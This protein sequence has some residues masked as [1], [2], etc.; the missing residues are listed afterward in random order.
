MSEPA[1]PEHE[2]RPKALR[3]AG[4]SIVGIPTL[5]LTMTLLMPTPEITAE[6]SQESAETN[7]DS[8][9]F[10]VVNARVFDGERT[11]PKATV[12]VENGHIQAMGPDLELPDDLERVDGSGHTLMPG[13]LDAHV[14]TWGSSRADA[15]RFGVT[16][17]LDQFT[18][19]TELQKARKHRDGTG[20]AGLADLFSA[21]YLA[22][23]DGGHGTQF[24]MPV[25]Q[26][27]SPEAADAW[28]KARKEEGSDWIKIVVEPGWGQSLPTLDP[29]TIAALIDA[30]HRQGLKAV[31]HASL[32]DDALRVAELGADGLVHVWR[33]REIDDAELETL[34]RS[35]IFVVPTLVVVE[36]MVDPEP[37]MAL[38]EGPLGS[39]LSA[40]QRASLERRFPPSTKLDW[41]VPTQSVRRLA[42]AGVP[43]LAGSDAPNPS[44]AFGF[45]LHREL[46]LLTE[47]GLSPEQ[48]LRA[49]TS[50]AADHFGVPKRGRIAEGQLADLVLVA[51]DPTADITATQ[52]I[53]KV[54]KSG[55]P[56]K[57]AAEQQAAP[58]IA[59]AP[60]P[61][62]TLLADF[63]NGLS[64]RSGQAW[65]KTTDDRM[66]GKSVVDLQVVDG[67]LRITGELLQGA[68]FPW[69]GAMTFLGPNP[70]VAV[71]FS[72]RKE[73]SFRARGDG[74]SYSVM[75]FS[76]DMQG[77]PPSLTFE[78]SDDWTRI[79][80][81]LKGFRGAEPA[82]LRAVSFAATGQLGGFRFEID[83]VE[84]R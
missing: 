44:T 23:V 56:V 54:W 25:P 40:P 6:A 50:L 11:H 37:S 36:G 41:A 67:A 60:A 64:S 69:A 46:Q 3:W 21:G 80:L 63:D 20:D 83:D 53:R 31:V 43:I 81:P 58:E 77:I 10:A 55:R 39:S 22:T 26:V 76:G 47:N 71:D 16:T 4:L 33:D 49:A 72:A 34:K 18:S 73:L 66:G 70:S 52:R 32:L 14:H 57:L 68:M 38:A 82:K 59:T 2:H 17:V 61:D 42:E 45:S 29:P 5:L 51:G 79:T 7:S 13:L 15:V 28:V 12:W 8:T 62:D 1:I 35:G 48:A 30:A 78:S 65:M 19:P 75:L 27:A 84:I 9:S 74:R 24:G